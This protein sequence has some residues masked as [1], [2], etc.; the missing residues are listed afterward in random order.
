MKAY[1]AGPWGFDSAGKKYMDEE[2]IPKLGKIQN[3][4]ILNPWELTPKD[5]IKNNPEKTALKIIYNNNIKAIKES[6]FIIAVLNGPQVDDGTAFELGYAAALGKKIIPY[7]D[8]WRTAC[9]DGK[10]NEF[11]LMIDVPILKPVIK[12]VNELV[13]RVTEF[14]NLEKKK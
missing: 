13:R 14:V 11:N 5:V 3:L 9:K 12:D 7:K 1:L 6:N 4:E 8:D 10:D 2:V